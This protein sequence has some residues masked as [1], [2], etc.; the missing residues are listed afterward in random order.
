MLATLLASPAL[1]SAAPARRPAAARA[2]YERAT[3]M[4]ATLMSQPEASRKRSDYEDV[5]KQ[6]KLVHFHDPAYV[7]SPPALEAVGELYAEMGRRFKSDEYYRTAIQSYRYLIEHYPDSPMARDARFTVAEILR[8][9]LNQPAEARQAFEEFL[10]QHPRAAQAPEGRQ[11]LKEI[12]KSLD[13]AKLAAAKP[14]ASSAAAAKGGPPGSTAVTS[15]PAPS[16]SSTGSSSLPEVTGIRRWVGPNYTRIVINVEGEVKF[17][18][19]RVPDPDRIVI[20]IQ[21]AKLSSSL[22]G[23][24]FPV[25]D[26]FLQQVRIGQFQPKITRVVLDV[27]QI[28]EYSVFTLPNPFRLVVDINGPPLEQAKAAAAAENAAAKPAEAAEKPLATVAEARKPVAPPP[29]EPEPRP[30]KEAA[31]PSPE[32]K[33]KPEVKKEPEA[34]ETLKPGKESSA[35]AKPAPAAPAKA[36]RPTVSGSQTLTRALGLKIGRIVIDPGH[37]GHDTGTIGPTGLR[38]KDLVLDVGKR[39]K[40][41]LEEKLGAEV[42]LTRDDDTFIPLEERTAIANEK[43]ADLFISIHANASRDKRAR[44]IETY[45]LNFTSDPE[46]LEVAGRENATSQESVHQLQDLIKKIALSEKIAESQDFAAKVQREVHSTLRKVTGEQK[47]RGVK[48]AP[49]VVLIGANMP[50]I[51]AE[52]SFLTNP[53][54][55]RLLKKGAH[56]DHIADA[57]YKGIA[58]YAEN[59]GGVKVAE[60]A[61]TAPASARGPKSRPSSESNF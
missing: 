30:K 22:V 3:R 27:T 54:D 51:L 43:G 8:A 7:K 16:A 59:L 55:E 32:E 45:Y 44:G 21:D 13:A 1:S 10:K 41:L 60:Q 53:Q 34:K 12:N 15:V 28:E 57:L 14:A 4:R 37:G 19:S 11:R 20:D 25:E 56:R 46:A 36:P 42:I 40:A 50:S 47:D 35:E 52:I 26:G 39:L 61:S 31:P 58:R 29:L 23:K 5:I 2:A 6:F 24:T 33:L 49:F 9:N 38:E 48:K 17:E 18:A